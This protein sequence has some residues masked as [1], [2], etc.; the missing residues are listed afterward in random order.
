MPKYLG[1]IGLLFLGLCSPV[2]GSQACDQ[3][4]APRDSADCLYFNDKTGTV[5]SGLKSLVGLLQGA[6][7]TGNKKIGKAELQSM[8]GMSGYNDPCTRGDTFINRS[9]V[10]NN[11]ASACFITTNAI[12]FSSGDVLKV[13]I[14]IP[15][16]LLVKT[17]ILAQTGHA[18]IPILDG[19]TVLFISNKYLQMGFGGQIND[20]WFSP[21]SAIIGTSHGCI[22]YN[23]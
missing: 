8:F 20:I 16:T 14:A 4:C 6:P 23:F 7:T 10:T 21:A 2:L 1:T 18:T 15:K 11:G 13:A 17:E 12:R 5:S 3:I 22:R 19:P 9:S